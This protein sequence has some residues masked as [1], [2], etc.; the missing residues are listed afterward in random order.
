VKGGSLRIEAYNC[1]VSQCAE[2]NTEYFDKR[3]NQ[4]NPNSYHDIQDQIAIEQMHAN[5][6]H[7]N[8]D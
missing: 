3:G 2:K 4:Q 8:A 6:Q 7:V 1:A 5:T